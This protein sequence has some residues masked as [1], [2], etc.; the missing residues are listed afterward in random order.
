MTVSNSAQEVWVDI[1]GCEGAYAVSDQGNV[2]SLERW[3]TGGKGKRQHVPGKILKQSLDSYGYNV[4]SIRFNNGARRIMKVHRLVL[5]AF[6]G[7]DSLMCCHGD[8][9]KGNNRLSNLRYGTALDNA[10]DRTKHG[11]VV[12]AS[13]ESNGAAKLTSR[14]VL[15]IRDLLA[16]KVSHRKIAA[17]F[18]VAAETVRKISIG[19][20]WSHI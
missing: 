9:D 17:L 2:K 15:A 19:A 6:V 1:P 12:G 7:D 20:T 4:V 14:E 8:G 10:E 11:Q 3:V 18:G 5:L 16:T 13:G